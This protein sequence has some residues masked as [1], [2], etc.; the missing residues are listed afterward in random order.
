MEPSTSFP[1]FQYDDLPPGVLPRP[2]MGN[3]PSKPD[4]LGLAVGGGGTIYLAS[5]D[6]RHNTI[7]VLKYDHNYWQL[8]GGPLKTAGKLHLAGLA[9]APSSSQPYITAINDPAGGGGLRVWQFSPAD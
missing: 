5:T 7:D 6:S 9:V 4:E 1:V 8:V 2:P 3:V